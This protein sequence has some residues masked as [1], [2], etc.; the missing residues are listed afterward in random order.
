MYLSA[1]RFPVKTIEL[2]ASEKPV[3]MQVTAPVP[4]TVVD[5]QNDCALQ[6]K[7]LTTPIG[8]SSHFVLSDAGLDQ[9]VCAFTYHMPLLKNG[10]ALPYT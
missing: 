8:L 6:L 5:E 2:S 1:V 10:T 9:T 4:E 3:G 7:N